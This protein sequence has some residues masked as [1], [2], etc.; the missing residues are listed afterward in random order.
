MLR[1]VRAL[2]G[3]SNHTE[4]AAFEALYQAMAPRVYAYA[5]RHS[6]PDTAADIVAEVFLVAWRRRNAL[7]DD[8]L[9]WLLVTARNTLSAHRRSWSRRAGLAHEMAAISDLAAM[10]DAPE[11]ERLALVR[12]FER[13][14]DDDRET[15]LLVGWDG[16]T[17]TEAAVVVGCS[18]NAF[19]ARLSR[20]RRR[21]DALTSGT[22][23]RARLARLATGGL[24]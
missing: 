12:A 7:P 24:S 4:P 14:S 19:A 5:R 22:T 6:D 23:P 21:F 20:A 9:P 3:V 15:L 18:P 13:L 8:A 16:L 1:A 11:T 10:S 17:P 2:P